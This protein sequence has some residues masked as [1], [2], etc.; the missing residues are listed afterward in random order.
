M[1]NKK[2]T[3]KN[4]ELTQKLIEYI[5]KGEDVPELPEDV[6]FVPF[7]KKDKMLNKANEELLENLSKE[8]KPIAIAE[9]PESKNAPWKITP[10]NF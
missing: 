9:E 2:Q 4:I 3:S 10:V 1:S 7:S 8:D 5:I 6:S